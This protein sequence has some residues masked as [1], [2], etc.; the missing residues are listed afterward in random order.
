MQAAL[1]GNDKAMIDIWN[2]SIKGRI[3]SIPNKLMIKM[4]RTLVDR[5]S[6]KINQKKIEY[7]EQE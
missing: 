5:R 3:K 4:L 1:N 7:D 6:K 2:S